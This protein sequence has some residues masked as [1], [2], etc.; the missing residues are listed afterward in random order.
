MQDPGVTVFESARGLLN[1][2]VEGMAHIN[3]S[4]DV[5]LKMTQE[6]ANCH[7]LGVIMAQQF[8]LRASLKKFGKEGKVAV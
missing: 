4:Q 3:L 1:D 6:E 7:V 2:F 5:A 8:N